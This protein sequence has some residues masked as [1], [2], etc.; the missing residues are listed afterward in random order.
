MVGSITGALGAY[1]M[2][3]VVGLWLTMSGDLVEKPCP[4][5]WE[6]YSLLGEQL[7]RA[8]MPQGC[9]TF[10]SGVILSSHSYLAIEVKLAHLEAQNKYLRERERLLEGERQ[11]LAADIRNMKAAAG[12]TMVE[13]FLW[14]GMGFL[15]GYGVGKF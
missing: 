10:A 4:T 15:G 14:M 5:Q 12:G 3:S 6:T 1:I 2:T 11:L 13:G 9:N 7:S 8:R